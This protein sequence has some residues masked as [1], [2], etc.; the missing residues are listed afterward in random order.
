MD[1]N[2]LSNSKSTTKISSASNPGL[3][4]DVKRNSKTAQKYEVSTETISAEDL[5]Q[6]MTYPRE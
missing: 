6:G 2:A 5:Q 4:T 1:K 3:I